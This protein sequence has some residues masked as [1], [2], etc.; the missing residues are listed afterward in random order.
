[1]TRPA[2]PDG[3]LV[4]NADGRWA[5]WTLVLAHRSIR[6]SI[7]RGADARRIEYTVDGP[8][9]PEAIEALLD[10]TETLRGTREWKHGERGRC[11][12][13]RP[14]G[15]G[16]SVLILEG[17]PAESAKR[18]AEELEAAARAAGCAVLPRSWKPL[19]HHEWNEAFNL[20]T[21]LCAGLAERHGV[22]A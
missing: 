20:A 2:I 1:V 10:A 14:L 16:T 4:R 12:L 18:A 22:A 13:V 17:V 8:L 6:S 21:A 9:S 3:R 19:R 15:Y 7:D 11:W 5:V